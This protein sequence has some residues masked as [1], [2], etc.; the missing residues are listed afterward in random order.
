V[1]AETPLRFCI[2]TGT[3]LRA[4]GDE[5]AAAERMREVNPATLVPATPLRVGVGSVVEAPRLGPC[6]RSAL[7]LEQGTEALASPEGDLFLASPQPATA[8]DMPDALV[9]HDDSMPQAMT[10]TVEATTRCNFRCTFCYGRHLEQGVMTWSTFM[11][12]LDALP[13]LRAV[14]FTGEGE[15][16]VNKSLFRMLE[17]CRARGLW[18][19]LTS[20]GTLLTEATVERLLALGL[21][22]LAVSFESLDPVRFARLRRGGTAEVMVESLRRV[23]LM[24][25][26]RGARL[27]LRLWITLLRDALDEIDDFLRLGAEVGADRVEFQALNPLPAY[28]RYYDDELRANLLTPDE[29]RAFAEA[30]ERSPAARAALA[31]LVASYR[32]RTC[33]IFGSA[34]MVYWQGAVTPC[35]LLKV[36][37]FTPVG[38]V[39]E[40]SFGEIWD[41]EAF[42]FFRFALRHSMVL[43]SCQGCPMIH[44]A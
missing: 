39:A 38:N 34:T 15:S 19:H 33:D 42:R 3:L 14:E 17:E 20:N 18:T 5:C 12:A 23:H 28:A 10:M 25:E 24:R 43:R 21:D 30:P 9:L 29:V 1:V 16:L 27:E 35:R 36:P 8:N 13:G 4:W 6:L 31:E 40:R 32:A 11:A 41:D 2:S 44:A 26:R 7:G 22:S 37:D